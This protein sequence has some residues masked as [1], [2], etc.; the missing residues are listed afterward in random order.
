MT[1]RPSDDVP[2]PRRT[3]PLS[4]TIAQLTG[5]AV[6]MWGAL[7][8]TWFVTDWTGSRI[9][10]IVVGA[11]FVTPALVWAL[12]RGSRAVFHGLAAAGLACLLAAVTAVFGP[13]VARRALRP[14]PVG[15][16][17]PAAVNVPPI[18]WRRVPA[19]GG[20]VRLVGDIVRA[21]S[22]PG[23]VTLHVR[24]SDGTIEQVVLG[25]KSSP[26]RVLDVVA[27]DDDTSR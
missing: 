20:G 13:D 2:M 24:R 8:V 11:A 23:G 10:G 6:V 12:R 27:E 7:A 5:A 25:A 19:N 18:R 16:V 22:G 15:A 17:A 14:A 4:A 26:A 9:A 1:E 3:A 21:D